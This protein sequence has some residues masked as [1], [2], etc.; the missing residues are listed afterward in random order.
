MID[1]KLHIPGPVNVSDQTYKAMC[2]PVMGHRS[3]DFV[4]LYQACQPNLQKLFQTTRPCLSFHLQ[5][6]GSY[7]R[8][9]T[10]IFVKKVLCCMC[11]A[12]S[13]KWLDVA[14]RSGLEADALQVEWGQHIEP[15][16]LKSKLSSGEYDVVTLVH[17]ET[18]CG[19]MN[20]LSGIMDVLKEFPRCHISN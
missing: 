6:M 10:E 16:D 2:T 17:N 9:F 8:C 20:P 11:G 4:D 7:G 18:S 14:H 19:M 3:A 13:D 5:C 12:F 1:Y 15:E